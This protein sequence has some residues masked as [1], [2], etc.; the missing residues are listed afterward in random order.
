MPQVIEK[1]YIYIAQPPLYKVKKGQK[2]NYIKDEKAL[3]NHLL[4]ENFSALKFTGASL[5]QDQTKNFILK[6][7]KFDKLLKSVSTRY[8]KNILLWILSGIRV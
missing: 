8:D 1:G 2:E 4:S 7:E 5:T 3:M 6:I